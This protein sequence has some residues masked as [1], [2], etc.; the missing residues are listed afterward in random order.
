MLRFRLHCFFDP[1]VQASN[2]FRAFVADGM[3]D[4]IEAVDALESQAD[5][6]RHTSRNQREICVPVRNV[7]R[8]KRQEW[9]QVYSHYDEIESAKAAH[10]AAAIFVEEVQA[11][12]APFPKF[13]DD[14]FH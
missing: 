7:Q 5:G 6:Y 2:H 14:H 10:P 11:K 9:P 3:S 13:G 12:E 1:R 8:V 4:P